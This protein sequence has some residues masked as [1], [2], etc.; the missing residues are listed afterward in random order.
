M[1]I[2]N[3]YSFQI[4]KYG[5]VTFF[6]N[7]QKTSDNFQHVPEK[8]LLFSLRFPS[9]QP[10][11]VCW[12][13]Y[14]NLLLYIMYTTFQFFS[15][16]NETDKQKALFLKY[17]LKQSTIS[18]AG[19]RIIYTQFFFPPPLLFPSLRVR[20]FFP[21]SLFIFFHTHG[22][23]KLHSAKNRIRNRNCINI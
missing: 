18:L 2:L 5:H 7:R 23:E 20:V 3:D 11:R 4:K 22:P 1:L 6:S 13:K 14:W 16:A 9:K 15:Y 19:T 17:L 12:K 8:K 10:N 21:P